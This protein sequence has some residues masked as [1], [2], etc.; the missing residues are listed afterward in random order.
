MKTMILPHPETNN[1]EHSLLIA[2]IILRDTY[3]IVGSIQNLV[4]ILLRY[5]AIGAAIANGLSRLAGVH[6]TDEGLT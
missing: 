1:S 3:M 6:K 2:R 5:A 4:A